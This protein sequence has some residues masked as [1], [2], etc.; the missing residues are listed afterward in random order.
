MIRF[1]P[2]P[3]NASEFLALRAETEWGVPETEQMAGILAHSP[4]GIVAY[5]GDQLVGMARCVGDGILILYMQDVIIA[6]SHRGHGIGKQLITHLIRHLET[7][8]SADCTIGLFAAIG[9][10]G[11]YEGLGFQSR[12]TEFY[13]PGMHGK[14]SD[15]LKCSLAI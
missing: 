11:F 2:R 5:D 8:C 13:G 7:I 6:K 10:S 14:Y 4:W 1:T 9:Q 12:N 15:L 3:P